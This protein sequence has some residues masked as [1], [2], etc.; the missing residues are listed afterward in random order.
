MANTDA[1]S[2]HSADK[3]KHLYLAG[4]AKIQDVKYFPCFYAEVRIDFNDVRTGLKTTFSLN[5][6]MEIYSFSADLLWTNDMVQ[7]VDP[8]HITSSAPEGARFGSLPEYVDAN[9]IAQAETQ[10]IQ[11]LLRSFAAELYRNS[12]L[13]VYSNSGESRSDFIGRC[14][15]LFNGTMRGE[16]DLM[17]EV[18][19]RRLEQLKGKYLASVKTNPSEHARIES[20]RKDIFLR[21][22]DR[23]AETFLFGGFA[24]GKSGEPFR[25]SPGMLELEERLAALGI[26]AQNAIANL[27]KS[28]KDKAGA[29]DEYILHPNL[30]DIHFVR[31]CIL[32]MPKKAA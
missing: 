9:F 26:E 7:A 12:F 21:Y 28:Y 14:M 22:S 6:A 29:L 3:V 15:E 23:I 1:P 4:D 25:I 19:N 17:H 5:K 20:H 2:L 16:L 31:S 30:K 18:F 13:N 8:A 11:Y 10:F 27:V 32:W 24:S